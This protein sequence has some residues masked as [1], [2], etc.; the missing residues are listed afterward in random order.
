MTIRKRI[1]TATII[2]N[3]IPDV[4]SEVCLL[5]VLGVFYHKLFHF[6]LIRNRVEE[7]P[8]SRNV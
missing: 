4:L 2:H 6:L 8:D 5:M 1:I 7:A 3:P